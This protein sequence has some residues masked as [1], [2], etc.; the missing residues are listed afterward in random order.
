MVT[1]TPQF[2]HPRPYI[3]SPSPI[4]FTTKAPTIASPTRLTS[5]SIQPE[6]STSSNT[7]AEGSPLPFPTSQVIQREYWLSE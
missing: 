2:T 6:A 5:T 7:R 3:P 4:P 1:H